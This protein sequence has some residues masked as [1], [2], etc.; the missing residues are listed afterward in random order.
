V[1]TGSEDTGGSGEIGGSEDTGGSEETGDE[2]DPSADSLLSFFSSPDNSCELTNP[3][4]VVAIAAEAPLM[5]IVIT[6]AP[7]RYFHIFIE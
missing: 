3:S 7:A 5:I 6:N 4:A 1:C 2:E